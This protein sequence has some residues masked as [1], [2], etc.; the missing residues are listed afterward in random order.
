[1]S[2]TI[3]IYHFEDEREAMRWLPKNLRNHYMLKHPDWVSPNSYKDVSEDENERVVRFELY[4]SQEQFIIEYRVYRS[5]ELFQEKCKPNPGDILLL[6]VMKHQ[7]NGEF[8]PDGLDLFQE[9]LRHEGVTLLLVTGYEARVK[10]WFD[11]NGKR[12]LPHAQ[13]S[14]SDYVIAKPMDIGAF[15]T[16]LASK[17][18]VEKYAKTSK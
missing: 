7:A 4:P 14:L 3:T 17:L 15:L 13:M 9:F 12:V 16:K 11:N 6:D 8:T 18:G 1:M 5:R 2:R 10:E